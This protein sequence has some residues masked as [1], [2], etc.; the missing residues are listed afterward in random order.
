MR[1]FAA[2]VTTKHHH[3]LGMIACTALQHLKL[4]LAE[5]YPL[6]RHVCF[7][8]KQLTA[9]RLAQQTHYVLNLSSPCACSHSNALT[10]TITCGMSCSRLKPC[11]WFAHTRS[12]SVCFSL[13]LSLKLHTAVSHCSLDQEGGNF[14]ILFLL[15]LNQ[16]TRRTDCS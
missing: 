10:Q 8:L 14:S 7:F 16:M 2:Q 4:I 13:S 15:F 1:L 11:S 6:L 12:T 3:T 9:S 5:M